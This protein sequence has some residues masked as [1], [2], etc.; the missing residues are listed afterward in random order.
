MPLVGGVGHVPATWPGC[1]RRL[2]PV[3][4]TLARG[5]HG[6]STA[7]RRDRGPARS[8]GRPR[9]PVDPSRG[10]AAPHGPPHAVAGV[11]RPGA[12][13]GVAERAAS[14]RRGRTRPR[15]PRRRTTAARGGLH[16]YGVGQVAGLPAAGA[17]VGA[18]PAAART[19]SAARRCSTSRP[20]RRWRRTSSAS[21]RALGV[22]D[23]RGDHARRRLL[24][25]AAGLGPRPRR[26][27]ADQPRHAAP[28]DAAR[29]RAVVEVLRDARLRRR[30]RVPPLPRGV[31][32]PRRADPA[33]A[34]PGV[35]ALRAAPDLR[36]RLGHRRR[37]GG[38][39]RAAD[40]PPVRRGH[41][42][43][44]PRGQVALALWEPPFVRT[45]ARTAR[46]SPLRDRGDRRPAH[47]PRARG[48]PHP[49]LHPLPP[50]RRDRLAGHPPPP[51]R[52]E[53]GARRRGWPPTAAATC[54]RTDGRSS[55][56]CKRGSCWAWPPPTPWSSASTSPASTR[57]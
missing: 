34:A 5:V 33:P 26:V 35:R 36:A 32:R 16:R 47:R 4:A 24:A 3:F 40:R 45:R 6:M 29:P 44:L 41:R 54:P 22:P 14:S 23:L 2:S 28:L 48:R 57:C 56:R 50:G 20:P 15:P 30:R 53:P 12:R 37:A 31:R 9:G 39:R 38:L 8:P 19:A 46:R 52:G 42:R 18:R 7:R 21:L 27:P 55:R 43:R 51:R 1:V 17:H 11:G 10:A 13:R 25:R 49:G